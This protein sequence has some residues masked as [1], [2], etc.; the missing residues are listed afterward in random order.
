LATKRGIGHIAILLAMEG[1]ELS[2][3]RGAF[4]PDIKFQVGRVGTMKAG[5]IYGSIITAARREGIIDSGYRGE[6]AIYAAVTD[7][8]HGVCRGQILL[9]EVLR[10]VA[11]R[12][13][14]VRGPCIQTEPGDWVA[15]AFFG[16]I[17][18][19]VKGHE[20]EVAGLGLSPL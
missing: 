4:G 17:G 2:L 1:D 10:T 3:A 9:G 14:V 19:P 7:A 13:S 6:H 16:T 15:V 5:D 20:H 18:S 8:L 12:F 11:L